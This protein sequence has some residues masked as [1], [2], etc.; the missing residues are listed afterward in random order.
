MIYMRKEEEVKLNKIVSKIKET[1]ELIKNFKNEF[2]LKEAKKVGTG[3][4]IFM[5]K[6]NIGDKFILIKISEEQYK[7]L[8][9]NKK[10]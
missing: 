10:L 8:N 2:S 4:H 6:E 1:D 7:E 9:K 3:S 5:L